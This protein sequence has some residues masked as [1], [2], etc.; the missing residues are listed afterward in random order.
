MT[1]RTE[2]VFTHKNTIKF[3]FCSVV[4]DATLSHFFKMNT[5]VCLSS[6]HYW[7]HMYQQIYA[8]GDVLF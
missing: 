2:C 3:I 5:H 1:G 6:G 7:E 4:I 8:V